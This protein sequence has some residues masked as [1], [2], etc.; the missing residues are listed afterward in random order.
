[1]MEQTYPA[2]LRAYGIHRDSGGPGRWRGGCG[3]VREIELLAPEATFAIRIDGVEK[4]P[5]GV[6][7]GNAAAPAGRG[8]PGNAA[9][10]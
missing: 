6:K 9:G 8:Q 5:W 10:A 2:R 4:P 3:V 7:A 1:M